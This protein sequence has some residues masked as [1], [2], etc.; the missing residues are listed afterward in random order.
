MQA[1]DG[2]LYGITG[3]G[4]AYATNNYSGSGTIFKLTLQGKLTTLYS[5]CALAGCQYGQD[6]GGLIQGTDGNFYGVIGLGAGVLCYD[7]YGCGSIFELTSTGVYSTLYT[8]CEELGEFCSDG[9]FPEAIIQATD[10][11]F[12]GTTGRGG[13]SGYGTAFQL[14]TGLAPFIHT[15]TA[16]GKTGSSVIILGNNLTGSTRVTFNGLSASFKVAS[17]TEITATVPNSATSGPVLVTTPSGI[18]TSNASFQ[19]TH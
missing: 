2:D 3:S 10:G 7:G 1:A 18:L 9:I 19:I 17:P 15:V 14:S 6:A 16:S 13:P 5:F 8:F 11:N 12:Y 4:G